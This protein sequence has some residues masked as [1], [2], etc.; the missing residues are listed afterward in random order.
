MPGRHLTAIRQT[1]ETVGQR[2][3]V[4]QP[5]L[6]TVGLTYAGVGGLVGAGLLATASLTPVG[7]VVQQVAAPAQEVVNSATLSAR[8][9]LGAIVPAPA[10]RIVPPAQPTL[11]V[12]E[13][14]N[15]LETPEAEDVGPA[16]SAD[17]WH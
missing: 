12:E 11:V 2:L 7:Q 3:L 17:P 8:G 14:D 6:R 5:W 9:A 4:A 16:P 13:P 15:A 10:P 1:A